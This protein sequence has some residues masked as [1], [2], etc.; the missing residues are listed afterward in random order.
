MVE[1]IKRGEEMGNVWYGVGML[2]WDDVNFPEHEV[3]PHTY[4]P[5]KFNKT[6]SAL[7]R[8]GTQR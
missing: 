2:K 6:M 4:I 3:P 1:L 5:N 7:H 8:A